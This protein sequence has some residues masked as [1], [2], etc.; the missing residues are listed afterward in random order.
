MRNALVAVVVI[1]GIAVG[2][3]IL[4]TRRNKQEQDAPESRNVTKPAE[5]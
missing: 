3:V 5:D 1:V 2:G 4:A